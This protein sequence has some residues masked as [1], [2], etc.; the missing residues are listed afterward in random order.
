MVHT[1]GTDGTYGTA[2]TKGGRIGGAGGAIAP[3]FFELFNSFGWLP[4][5]I[6]QQLN[7]SIR[8]YTLL[9]FECCDNTPDYR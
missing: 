9:K 7:N 2:G 4:N 6:I 3:H 5:S 8:I 1:Y